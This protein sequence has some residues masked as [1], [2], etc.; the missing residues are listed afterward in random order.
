[1][2]HDG[3][4][5]AKYALSDGRDARDIVRTLERVATG[6]AAPATAP[7]IFAR[8]VTTLVPMVVPP[9]GVAV[10]DTSE[11]LLKGAPEEDLEAVLRAANERWGPTKREPGAAVG[12]LEFWRTG[13]AAQLRSGPGLAGYLRGTAEGFRELATVAFGPREDTRDAQTIAEEFVHRVEGLARLHAEETTEQHM[14]QARED[15]IEGV[16]THYRRK[17][18]ERI[19]DLEEAALPE[20]GAAELQQERGARREHGWKALTGKGPGHGRG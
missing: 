9:A 19:L 15:V 2:G 20:E 4:N 1:V 6:E 8:I 18:L 13:L 12:P 3:D 14:S 11:A 17:V 10:W 7:G 5:D 16:P